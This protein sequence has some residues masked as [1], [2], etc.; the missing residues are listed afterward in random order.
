MVTGVADRDISVNVNVAL[1]PVP[2]LTDAGNVGSAEY[3][4][5]IASVIVVITPEETVATVN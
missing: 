3:A 4:P 5:P 2:P 1:E